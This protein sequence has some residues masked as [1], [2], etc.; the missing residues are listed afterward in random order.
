MDSRIPPGGKGVQPGATQQ[1][2]SKSTG[3]PKKTGSFSTKDVVQ[4]PG[5]SYIPDQHSSESDSKAI[6]EWDISIAEAERTFSI[7]AASLEE[8]TGKN[9]TEA[10][11]AL[12]KQL[13]EISSSASSIMS[14]YNKRVV[15]LGDSDELPPATVRQLKQKISRNLRV[16]VEELNELRGQAAS[17]SQKAAK[18]S[19]PQLV[20]DTQTAIGRFNSHLASLKGA[21]DAAST[22]ISP[23][24]AVAKMDSELRALQE[25]LPQLSKAQQLDEFSTQARLQIGRARDYAS[26]PEAVQKSWSSAKKS[27]AEIQKAVL[28][29]TY[30]DVLNL[31][32]N[33]FNA[34]DLSAKK[35][36]VKLNS[37]EIS[38]IKQALQAHLTNTI[39]ALKDFTTWQPSPTPQPSP[40]VEY[41]P[42]VTSSVSAP[43]AIN[44]QKQ[45]TA[46][47]RPPALPLP[48][49]F[50]D[51]SRQLVSPAIR[52]LMESVETSTSP[53]DQTARMKTLQNHLVTHYEEKYRH[54]EPLLIYAT[55]KNRLMRGT[56]TEFLTS[57]Q[58]ALKGLK[59]YKQAISADPF[60]DKALAALKAADAGLAKLD[61]MKNKVPPQLVHL[62]TEALPVNPLPEDHLVNLINRQLLQG[63]GL[64]MGTPRDATSYQVMTDYLENALTKGGRTAAPH[65]KQMLDKTF[66][67]SASVAA[68]LEKPRSPEEASALIPLYTDWS[69]N[70]AA[71]LKE[72]DQLVQQTAKDLPGNDVLE[73]VKAYKDLTQ[74]LQ[75]QNMDE[76][77]ETAAEQSQQL[78]KVLQHHISGMIHQR[79]NN[80]KWLQKQFSHTKVCDEVAKEL[81]TQLGGLAAIDIEPGRK[82]SEA[83]PA[84]ILNLS[85]SLEKKQCR[86]KQCRKKQCRKK[87]CRKNQRRV[88]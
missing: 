79:L 66:E 81:N 55:Q 23:E 21:L 74:S 37:S 88:C 57:M 42:P 19:V 18:L 77:A 13:T 45:P 47:L 4:Y 50:L 72:V 28:N 64:F 80:K 46:P 5:K 20:K 58:H 70:G 16:C 84:V 53:T 49:H 11:T 10:K 85:A 25:R 65:L 33:K 30:E 61:E 6:C 60:D 68:L 22:K 2:L 40:K 27:Q 62:L 17:T 35:K 51:T 63:D 9:G 71:V 43:A 52:A 39:L 3:L 36:K 38:I 7:A 34:H 78:H 44:D 54:I 15:A 26:K 56:E 76:A 41:N 31:R 67:S 59:D 32:K 1:E 48:P 86:K 73:G 83:K 87:Q 8:Q 69:A 24:L 75:K 14:D 29:K 12:A 82:L